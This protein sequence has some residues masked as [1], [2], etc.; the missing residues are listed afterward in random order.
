MARFKESLHQFPRIRP[1]SGR[2]QPDPAGPGRMRP[3]PDR[4]SPD[5]GR[6]ETSFKCFPRSTLSSQPN[7]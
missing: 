7:F 5:A 4:F 6:I 2:M 1:E 3:G